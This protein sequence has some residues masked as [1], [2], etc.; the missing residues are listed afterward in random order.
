MS[1]PAKTDKESLQLPLW[2]VLCITTV[3]L[4]AVIV[5]KFLGI[6]AISELLQPLQ[7]TAEIDAFLLYLLLAGAGVAIFMTIISLKRNSLQN[8]QLDLILNTLKKI[9]NDDLTARSAILNKNRSGELARKLNENLDNLSPSDQNQIKYET[10]QKSQMELLVQISKIREGDLTVIA[11]ESEDMNG[12][13]GHHFNTLS[14]S[15]SQL[16]HSVENSAGALEQ[17]SGKVAEQNTN[18]LKKNLEKAKEAT[19]AVSVLKKSAREIDML[20]QLTG[21]TIKGLNKTAEDAKGGV[22]EGTL[23][24]EALKSIQERTTNSTEFMTGFQE[25]ILEIAHI[26]KALDDFADRT[27]ILALNTSIQTAMSD[28]AS[29][30][31]TEITGEIQRLAESSTAAAQDMGKVSERLKRDVLELLLT[32][33]TSKQDVSKCL[34]YLSESNSSIVEAAGSGDKLIEI[35]EAVHSSVERQK[36]SMEQ[37]VQDLESITSTLRASSLSNNETV[38]SMDNIGDNIQDIRTSLAAFKVPSNDPTM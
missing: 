24:E 29:H 6:A 36:N 5:V 4:L 13:I 35:S 14:T 30:S 27:G 18:L 17:L 25:N 10:F 22:N 21:K 12:A 34:K 11:P 15:I 32:I 16:I 33:Q 28:D 3:L 1:Q 7:I 2:I 8:E 9:E 20:S 26:A 23:S 37:L 31:L 19:A 38:S